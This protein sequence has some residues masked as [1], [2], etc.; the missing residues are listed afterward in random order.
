MPAILYIRYYDPNDD[1]GSLLKTIFFWFQ[2]DAE[3]KRDQLLKEIEDAG[4]INKT[5]LSYK[6]E[7]NKLFY[8]SVHSLID[9]LN[10]LN[11]IYTT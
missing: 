4:G 6:G 5:D 2:E 3:R 1:E 8:K 11:N 9:A 10:E 7:I